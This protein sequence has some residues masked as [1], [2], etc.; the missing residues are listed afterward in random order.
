MRGTDPDLIGMNGTARRAALYVRVSTAGK[1]RR[2]EI[3]ACD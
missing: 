3:L 2:G 1:T